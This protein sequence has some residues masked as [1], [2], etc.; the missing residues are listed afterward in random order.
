MHE[1]LLFVGLKEKIKILFTVMESLQMQ[2]DLTVPFYSTGR[3]F[4]VSK[5][6]EFV[7]AKKMHLN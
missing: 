7:S 4:R 6:E 3:N 1:K 5:T 2:S